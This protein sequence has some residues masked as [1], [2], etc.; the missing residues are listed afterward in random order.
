MKS[1]RAFRSR[2][3]GFTLVELLVVIGI[4]A[5]LISILLPALSRAR[6][7]ASRIK[8]ASNLRSIVQASMI[9]CQENR[10]RPI[11]FPNED[12][13]DDSL[14]H[15][16]PRYIKS[17]DVA[18]CPGTSNYVRRDVYV[19]DAIQKRYEER[20]LQ[21]I[22]LSAPNGSANGHSYEPFAWY[23]AGV[24]TD[25]TVIDGGR[26]GGVN[27]QLGLE[28]H[29]PRYRTPAKNTTLS[30]IKRFGKLKKPATTILI[31][32]IDRDSSADFTKMNNWPDKGNNHGDK[33]AN[34]AFGDGH[35]EFVARGPE[36][37]KTFVNGY[38]GLAQNKVFTMS[39]APGLVITTTTIQGASF[40]RYI[41]TK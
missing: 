24:W 27:E 39:K 16:I 19:S 23:S 2:S 20:V 25:G 10:K 37:I 30:L 12:G 11:F 1:R 34:F 7:S 13:A 26:A 33:G 41:Y 5:L 38:Q 36:F 28:P 18:I 31:A 9:R 15:L 8:C 21:D 14:G 4:I 17:P 40:S 3:R 22:H 32:D 29:D 35:V 6:E